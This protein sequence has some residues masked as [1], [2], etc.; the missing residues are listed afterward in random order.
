MRAK[1]VTLIGVLALVVAASQAASGATTK[2][3][4]RRPRVSEQCSKSFDPYHASTTL[5]RACGDRILRLKHVTALPGG[6]KAYSY[7]GYTVLVPPR[8]FKPLKASDKQLREY[9]MPTRKQLGQAK[10]RSLM[11]HYRYTVPPTPYIAE[12]P[13]V[14]AP[15]PGAS[16][17]PRTLACNWPTCNSHWSGFVASTIP[18]EEVTAYWTEPHFVSAG[19]SGDAFVQWVGIG[20]GTTDYLAQDGTAF[21]VP[22]V[23]AH[24]AWVETINGSGTGTLDPVN[25][26]TVAGHNFYASTLWNSASSD[27]SYY[28][29][30]NTSGASYSGHSGTVTADQST[31]EVIS[32]RPLIN[33]KLPELSDYQHVP[34]TSATGYTAGRPFPFYS[35]TNNAIVMENGLDTL[36]LPGTMSPQS[37]FT[38]TWNA[39]S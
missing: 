19:C 38:T 36:S 27:F 33:N 3:A 11:R 25:L 24:Q 5:L 35:L 29:I 2:D 13:R 15:A 26:K 7:G 6:G 28:M 37:D 16:A 1:L 22:D 18:F 34:V 30:D 21:N 14:E 23:A 9:G 31:A 32:E 39:C 4:A 10:W 8:H 12:D 20:G 17:T